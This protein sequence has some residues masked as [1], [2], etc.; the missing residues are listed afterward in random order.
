MPITVFPSHN[1]LIL[2]NLVKINTI[3]LV[4]L[5]LV[6]EQLAIFAITERGPDGVITIFEFKQT[7]NNEEDVQSEREKQRYRCCK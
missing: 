5:L 2:F 1:L 3:L 4:A 7:L 6:E